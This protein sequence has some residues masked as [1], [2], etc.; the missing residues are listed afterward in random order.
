MHGPNTACEP[1]SWVPVLSR[2]PSS[3]ISKATIGREALEAAREFVGR[4]ATVDDVVPVIEFLASGH[5]GWVNGQDIQVDGGY[6]ASLVVGMPVHPWGPAIN[7]AG[8]WYGNPINL[9]SRATG[10][11][12]AS[13]VRVTEPARKAIGDPAGIEWSAPEARYLKGIRGEVLMYGLADFPP[14]RHG[15]V[16]GPP[17]TG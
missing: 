8:D 15:K 5:A 4:H 3:L 2:R 17:G 1:T 11:A 7:R 14:K 13:T 9:V 16:V 6:I 12:P 10:V